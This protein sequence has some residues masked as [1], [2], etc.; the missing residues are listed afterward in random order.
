MRRA[1]V[2]FS[3]AGWWHNS[4]HPQVLH[5][6]SVMIK[7]MGDAE[8]G[9][10]QMCLFAIPRVLKHVFRSQCGRSLVTEGKRILQE[11]DDVGFGFQVLRTVPVLYASRRFFA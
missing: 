7:G 2:S 11:L 4:V 1:S 8:W 6:L 9:H 5:H 10:V 3:S